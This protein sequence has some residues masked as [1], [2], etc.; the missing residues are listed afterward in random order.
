M[1]MRTRGSVTGEDVLSFE[2]LRIILFLTYVQVRSCSIPMTCT[3]L[4]GLGESSVRA[5][6][7]LDF[8]GTDNKMS[9]I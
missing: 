1:E 6:G 2:R 9:T 4:L 3:I 7:L 5:R 8:K